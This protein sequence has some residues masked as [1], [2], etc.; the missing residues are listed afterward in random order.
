MMIVSRTINAR[1]KCDKRLILLSLLIV[2]F[3]AGCA[4]SKK[5]PTE[6]PTATAAPTATATTTATATATVAPTAT[7]IIESYIEMRP[8]GCSEEQIPAGRV[9]FGFGA[10][11][12]DDPECSGIG[13]TSA[14][15]TINGEPIPPLTDNFTING[16]P[17]PPLTDNFNETPLRDDGRTVEVQWHSIQY[18]HNTYAVID[19]EPG[20]YQIHGT[21]NRLDW[22]EDR[23]CVLTVTGP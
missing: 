21:W 18:G 10:G 20:V 2:L 14:T 5:V 9:V 17:I 16:E 3:L 15:M 6:T 1:Q 7:E 8:S 12:G 11:C 22:F 13:D 23:T 19:L 4:V